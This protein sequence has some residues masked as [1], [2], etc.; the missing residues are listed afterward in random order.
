MKKIR[1]VA[2]NDTMGSY[3]HFRLIC[4]NDS[5]DCTAIQFSSID[6]T[7]LWQGSPEENKQII[8]L[9][10]DKPIT[11]VSKAK[12]RDRLFKVLDEV[13]PEVVIL[14]GWDAIPSLIALLWAM[15][16]NKPTVII[17]E[18]Q[19]HDFPR[20]RIKECFKNFL[21]DLIDSAFVGGINQRNY[22]VKLGFDN[23]MIFEGCD[24][25]DN[26]FFMRPSRKEDIENLKLPENYF[27]TSCRFV[28]K[29]NLKILIE[30]FSSLESVHTE[31]SLVLAGDGPLRR[32]LESLVLEYNLSDK[33]HFLGYLDYLT[34]KNVYAGASCFV[35]PSTTEQWGLVINEALASGIP[36]ICSKN[37]G[38][39]PNLLSGQHVGYVFDPLSSTDLLGKMEKII[40]ELKHTDF[41]SVA[42]EVISK[43]DRNKY[44]DSINKASKLGIK[45]YK[46]RS[47]V[48][49]L[50]L[51]LYIFLLK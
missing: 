3:H 45:E 2:L 14:S 6:H 43:W 48:K 51:K 20:Y 40:S 32:E 16:N 42:Q 37:V 50:S 19:E 4:A 11:E 24:I 38:S 18:S 31:W 21:L 25:V 29:K 36:V 10:D 8:T 33:V 1:A 49:I 9:F 26:K 41:T 47:F 44:S 46:K 23:D 7:N 27:L 35:L 28:E 5:L 22:L 13:D 12:I 15:E 34:M 17:S 39:A 30:A